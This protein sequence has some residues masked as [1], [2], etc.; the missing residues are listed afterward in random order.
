[1]VAHW[2]NGGGQ[3]TK[4]WRTLWVFIYQAFSLKNTT[5]SPV[6]LWLRVVWQSDVIDP[7]CSDNPARFNR[8]GIW[9][10]SWFTGL[11]RTKLLLCR[12]GLVAF[13]L[14]VDSEIKPTM[15]WTTEYYDDSQKT[16]D[17]AEQWIAWV[18]NVKG[19]RIIHVSFRCYF[20]VLLSFFPP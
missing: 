5:R 4:E 17:D 1:M 15:E 18:R 9:P 19:L 13:R 8:R 12:F 11:S 10:I 3:A 16:M 7:L 2:V 20:S 6:S 14:Q